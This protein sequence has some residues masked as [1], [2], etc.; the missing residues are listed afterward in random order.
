LLIKVTRSP[1]NKGFYFKLQASSSDITILTTKNKS[2]LLHAARICPPWGKEY[3]GKHLRFHAGIVFA[4][5]FANNPAA[6]ET[7]PG[8]SG[9]NKPGNLR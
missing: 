1:T 7:L 9:I 4:Y 6:L 3:P 8:C 2:Q 5:T